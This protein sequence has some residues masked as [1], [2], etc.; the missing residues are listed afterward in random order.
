MVYLLSLCRLSIRHALEDLTS[1]FCAGRELV[2]DWRAGQSPRSRVDSSPVPGWQAPQAMMK[3][4]V[5]NG[6]GYEWFVNRNVLRFAQ[7][8]TY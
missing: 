6:P 3:V 7:D 2:G 4:Q 8:G 1:V 5:P